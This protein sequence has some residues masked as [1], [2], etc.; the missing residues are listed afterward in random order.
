MECL[1]RLRC[2]A[3][4]LSVC[5]V[6]VAGGC[7][8]EPP[9]AA[10]ASAHPLA[11]RAGMDILAAGGNAFDA[12]VTVSA[13]LAVVE[14]SSS[15]LGGGGFWL[16]HRGDDG[17]EVVVD[18]RERA[19]LA[20]SRDMFLDADGDVV[21]D[22]S[23]TGALAAGI[24]GEA[25]A[26]VHIARHYG[27]L[28]LA[29]TLAPAIRLARDGFEVDEHYRRM[30]GFRLASLQDDEE[31][32]H[33]FLQDDAVPETGYRLRQPQLAETLNDIARQG[34]AG[35]YGGRVARQLVDGVRHNGG[36]WTLDDLARYQV[37][38]RRPVTGHYRGLR[39]T[40]AGPPSSGGVALLTMLNIL[41]GL[42]LEAEDE[43]TRTHLII[44]AMRRAY[45]D[46]ALY[47][48]DPEFVSVP[49]AMLTGAAHAAA[50]RES[51]QLDRATPSAVLGDA[52]PVM[53]GPDTTH[54]SVLDREG[55]RVAATLSI[56]YP[57]GACL[58]PPGT[59][60]LLND[61]MD[62]FSI[63]PGT[64]NAYGLVGAEANAVAPGKRPLSSMTPT[65]VENAD[66]VAILGT[67]GG[68]RIITM[69]L[70]AVLDMVEENRPQSWVSRPR[71]HHQYLP[72]VVQFEPGAFDR[73]VVEGLTAR[74]HRLTAL[75][76]P[77]GNM[78]AIYWDKKDGRVYAAS[79]PRG[80][81]AAQVGPSKE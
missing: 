45:R 11:T 16:L 35:F 27:R 38:E 12:A 63:K 66:G 43:A 31:T 61:E 40:S 7:R 69:V 19:P 51:I 32:A 59:G 49:V 75:D 29:R 56:N 37:V 21:P 33:I 17:F 62:D 13:V 76:G 81:G 5:L 1:R 80:S 52:A 57:F 39:I 36:L 8:E 73:V 74:G 4:L 41:S 54:F 26:L 70:L 23:L 20:A 10:I 24:P 30:A 14:P 55:N 50:L 79:D 15:G 3:F 72:D 9:A 65:F 78:Q 42:P 47:L 22:L 67:P 53:Q 46:R 68:S 6:I 18:G 44:E 28:P 2:G 60:V 77:Y 71:F 34:E 64:P 48:G 25:A 58:T